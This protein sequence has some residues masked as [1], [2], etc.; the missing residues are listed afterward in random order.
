MQIVLVFH[1]TVWGLQIIILLYFVVIQVIN[2]I[3]HVLHFC[4]LCIYEKCSALV[5]NLKATYLHTL[6]NVMNCEK[7]LLG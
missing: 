6:K 2:M 4:I 7:E 5:C 3:M 1:P